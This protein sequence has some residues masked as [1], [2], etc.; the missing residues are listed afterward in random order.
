MSRPPGK[1]STLCEL[2][3][4]AGVSTMTVSNVLR[5]TGRF[6]EE[7]RIR[8][9]EAA[10]QIQY[11]P[12]PEI[13]RLMR[14]L[15]RPA[16]MRA[17]PTIAVVG[18]WS[19]H[20][21]EAVDGYFQ[22]LY[23]GVVER[24]DRCGYGLD[25]FLVN[26]SL[27][28][29]RLHR[30][31]TTRGINAMLVMPWAKPGAHFNF[32]WDEFSVA[33]ASNAL[34][35]PPLHRSTP[36]HYNNMLLALHHARHLGYRRPGFVLRKEQDRASVHSWWAA[37]LWYM[38]THSN[39]EAVPILCQN[40]ITFSSF[41]N[42]FSKHQPDLII[43]S[44]PFPLEWAI[45]LGYQV[46][47]D[48]GFISLGGYGGHTSVTEV[49]QRPELVGEAAVDLLISQIHSNEKGIPKCPKVVMIEGSWQQGQTTRKQK[50]TPLPAKKSP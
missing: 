47:R 34:W 4:I 15:R 8:V 36:H 5:N 30:A 22:H 27:P 25:R 32:P 13:S 41:G 31:M 23:Q 14:R 21:T 11:R 18:T 16:H 50:S 40:A 3:E 12:D 6:S 45:R 29:N 28:V 7:T 19:P 1:Y 49:N 38:E 20:H 33:A 17:Q 43:G 37:Y 48:V 24:A 35:K 9:M 39:M 2:A 10:K 44:L 46:P 26:S 42:W